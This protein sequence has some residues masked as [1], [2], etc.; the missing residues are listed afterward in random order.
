MFEPV[1]R[2][3]LIDFPD[4][5]E[6]EITSLIVLPE[7]YKNADDTH[8]VASVISAA[9]DVKFALSKNAQIVVDRSMVEE[10]CIGDTTYNVILENY[11]FGI[12]S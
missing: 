6:E 5:L 4:E 11:I 1:N 8:A 9:P 12:L 2:F 3:I 7:D 10:I